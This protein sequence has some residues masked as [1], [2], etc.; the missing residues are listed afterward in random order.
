M[1]LYK[2]AG[3]WT[4]AVL[5]GGLS[6]CTD[7]ESPYLSGTGNVS[8]KVHIPT[9]TTRAEG[10]A[11]TTS[12]TYGEGKNI[13]RV[14]CYVY[15]PNKK[16]LQTIP[17][18]V[19]TMSVELP[20]AAGETYQL[21]FWADA[22]EG[23]SPYQLTSS[24]EWDGDVGDM[25]NRCDLTID[26][27]K[28]AAMTNPDYA[29]AFY[30][31]MEYTAGKSSE[32]DITLYRPFA[33]INLGTCDAQYLDEANYSSTVFGKAYPDGAQTTVS[34]TAPG[35][36]NL[37]D[38]EASKEEVAFTM[39]IQ[40]IEPHKDVKFP[41]SL[42][43]GR[44]YRYTNMAYVIIPQEGKLLP[45]TFNTYNGA[46]HTKAIWSNTYKDLPLKRNWRTNVMGSLFTDATDFT[47]T[48]NPAF[49]D[50]FQQD[51]KQNEKFLDDLVT[52]KDTDGNV[53][54]VITEDYGQGTIR[55]PDSEEPYTIVIDLN[56]H[57]LPD[58]VVGKNVTLRLL[59]DV[60][61]EAGKSKVRTRSD[62][63]VQHTT[64]TANPGS[65]IEFLGGEYECSPGEKI[66]VNNGGTIKIYGGDFKGQD[67]SEFLASGCKVY[68]YEEAPYSGWQYV[69]EGIA[70]SNIAQFDA[71]IAE[72]NIMNNTK[73]TIVEDIA[74]SEHKSYI[75][76]GKDTKIK[77]RQ[78]KTFSLAGQEHGDYSFVVTPGAS[79]Y[80][81]GT[82]TFRD[83]H[84]FL[85]IE[86][87]DTGRG[88]VIIESGSY[89]GGRNYANA[90]I[91]NNG[92]ILTIDEAKVESL[93][94][95]VY[96]SGSLTINSGEFV[97]VST[98]AEAPQYAL[99]I[100]GAESLN[101]KG[102]TFKAYVGIVNVWSCQQVNISGGNFY[103][104][105]GPADP[106]YYPLYINYAVAGEISGGNFHSAEGVFSSVYIENPSD[107]GIKFTGGSY[108]GMTSTLTPAAGYEW[109]SINIP[110]PINGC[111]P[112]TK[113]IV[114]SPSAARRR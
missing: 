28:L 2:I 99:Y 75:I 8:F 21:L 93:G 92:G 10:D 112:L 20:L 111:N 23:K 114:K 55:I 56:G 102:G 5:M 63:A 72:A 37:F 19:N 48:I 94:N 13:G 79:L 57:T 78:G 69:V 29:D 12:P 34:Y 88:R 18:D 64:F 26:Q 31:V 100:D 109:Q 46:D 45:L 51:Q 11:S 71:A 113:R 70:V 16:L 3:L 87:N 47:V 67:I 105:Y 15:K 106:L 66:I 65:R 52:K 25:V 6:G 41:G 7:P 81:G 84:R 98:D 53:H 38:G 14:E 103:V 30:Y 108:G 89:I 39:P 54:L 1:K 42:N 101:I 24:L 96:N 60:V 62:Y 82:G 97:N 43:D 58:V 61:S 50:G 73:I 83:E 27:A 36:M 22:G 32:E 90:L 91:Y 110:S 68:I 44:T 33:Q 85:K 49:T 4:C 59:N 80:L 76:T 95:C 35:S 77:V 74:V 104:I 107:C 17:V 86:S 9:A 40:P